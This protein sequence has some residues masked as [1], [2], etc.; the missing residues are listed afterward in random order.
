M[1]D[2]LINIET[3]ELLQ[4]AGDFSVGDATIQNQKLLLILNKNEIKQYPTACVGAT[5]FIDDEDPNE[6]IREIRK[7]YT[8]DGMRIKDLTNNNGKIGVDANYE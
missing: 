4:K 5:E 1:Q 3:G 6:L 7:E 2:I 8:K